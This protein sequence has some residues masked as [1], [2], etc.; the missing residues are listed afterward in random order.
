MTMD[1]AQ[2]TLLG[3]EFLDALKSAQLKMTDEERLNLWSELREGYCPD[4]GRQLLRSERVCHC[5]NDE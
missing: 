4:C 5:R 2:V 1:V 3:H